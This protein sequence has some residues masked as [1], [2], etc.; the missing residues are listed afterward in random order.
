MSEVEVLAAVIA[1]CLTEYGAGVVGWRDRDPVEV[2]L[3]SVIISAGWSRRE[4]E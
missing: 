4:V 3:A 1:E 2:A